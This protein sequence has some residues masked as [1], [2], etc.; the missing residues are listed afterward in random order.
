MRKNGLKRLADENEN[1]IPELV[2]VCVVDLLEVVQ[3]D[4]R[5]ADGM[6]D[7]TRKVIPQGCTIEKPGQPVPPT[8]TEKFRVEA[9]QIDMD[10]FVLL[11]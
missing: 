11:E 1:A 3:V 4:Q 5:H 6:P 7:K 8:L 9:H 10:R 2:A